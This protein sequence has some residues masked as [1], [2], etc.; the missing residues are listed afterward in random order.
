M[1]PIKL[2]SGITI[3]RRT[4]ICMSAGSMAM[5]PSFYS[6]VELFSP[7]RFHDYPTDTPKG[8]LDFVG[9]ENG[10]VHWGSGRFT[11]PGRWYASAVMKVFIALFVN[12]YN[13]RF[14]EGQVERLPNVYMDILVHFDY[15]L[16]R[17][18]IL[19]DLLQTMRPENL[20]E[21]LQT[22]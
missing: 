4:Y 1:T 2:S 15:F 3:P 16:R 17:M 5:D 18:Q 10:N 6:S 21:A 22:C 11:C 19:R 12:R 9:T 13:M 14:P 8:N 20:H 7:S